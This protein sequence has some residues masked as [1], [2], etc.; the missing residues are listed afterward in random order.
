MIL[1]DAQI[2][3]VLVRDLRQR[4]P[5][6]IQLGAFDQLQQQIERSFI[7]RCGNLV[8]LR[9]VSGDLETHARYY[10]IGMITPAK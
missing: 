8:S 3:Q 9:L 6:Y 4:Q 10:S 2:L 5:G 7:D 1:Q